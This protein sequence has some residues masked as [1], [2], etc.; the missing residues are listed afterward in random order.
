MYVSY[1]ASNP[2]GRQTSKSR[3]SL[4]RECGDRRV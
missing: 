1:Y 2:I 3:R 4:H